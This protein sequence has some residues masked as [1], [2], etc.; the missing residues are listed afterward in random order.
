M[1]RMKNPFKATLG[2]TPPVLV[3]RDDVLSDFE[4]ALF[5]G[6]G[7]HERISVVTGARGIGKTVL[8]N[9]FEDLARQQGWRVFSETATAGFPVRLRD[10]MFRELQSFAIDGLRPKLTSLKFGSVGIGLDHE[11][12]H[13]PELRLR[14]IWTKLLDA[15]SELDAR[16]G[17]DPVGVL[18]TLDEM[19][20]LH[21]AEVID[22]VVAVQHLIREEREIAVVMAGIPPAVKPLLASNDDQNPIT[23]LRRA[24]RL[25]LG[26]IRDDEV[27]RGLA[28][29]VEDAGASWDEG[30]LEF[31]VGAC[32]G[33]PF[34]IQLVGQWSFHFM[35]EGRIT[36]KSAEKGAAKAR[37]KLGQLV[38]EPAL[39]DLSDVDRTFLAAMALDEDS[40]RIGDIA[41]RMRVSSQYA[42]NYRRR[43]L[44]AEM[45]SSPRMGRVEFILPYMRDYLRE[46]IVT[47][48]F[49]D[50]GEL[51]LK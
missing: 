8:L 19:H 41:E 42:S 34:M 39:A 3:G 13:Q 47:D 23:F 35:A 43:L 36:L 9:A 27:A 46:H 49:G 14:E 10:S 28:D 21:R 32:G 48:I 7:A 25:Q 22:F 38:H 26:S 16:T 1:K 29:P 45:I 15:Q 33:Y 40:S 18:I 5:D 11:L 37:R 6:P 4:A 51:N 44:D 2:A 30:A 20:H 12:R 24:N 31:A 50:L 17:Q